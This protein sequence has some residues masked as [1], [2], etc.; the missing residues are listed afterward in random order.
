M[1]YIKANGEVAESM[2]Q[3]IIGLVQVAALR[4]GMDRDGGGTEGVQC[5]SFGL[6]S[7]RSTTVVIIGAGV[8]VCVLSW[9]MAI[10]ERA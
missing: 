2:L 9:R 3:Q 4:L 8:V 5:V 6:A 7:R 10:D 1:I